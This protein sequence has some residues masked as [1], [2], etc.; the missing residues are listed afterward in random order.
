MIGIR[1]HGNI[2]DQLFQYATARTLSLKLN[3]DLAF[4]FSKLDKNPNW[5]EQFNTVEQP[6]FEKY[7]VLKRVKK[8]NKEF[9]PKLME[10]PNDSCLEGD[11]PFEMYFSSREDQ[12]R[13][14]FTL[15]NPLSTENARWETEIHASRIPISIHMPRFEKA[16]DNLPIEYFDRCVN[17]LISNF[18]NP[19]LYIFTNDVPYC[20]QNVR[21][22]AITKFID[23]SQNPHEEIFLMSLCRHHIISTEKSSWWGAWLDRRDS[24]FVFY[25]KMYLRGLSAKEQDGR[26]SGQ[27]MTLDN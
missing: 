12:I 16:N 18:Q 7:V 5:L 1:I 17:F 19:E 8:S 25:P 3:T 13:K 20:I 6:K 24:K 23:S 15:K 2:G 9:D 27:W 10:T 22:P 21:F 11:F 4:D 26:I 14:D